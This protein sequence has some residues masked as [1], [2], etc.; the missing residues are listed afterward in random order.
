MNRRSNTEAVVA[1][2]VLMMITGMASW[3]YGDAGYLILQ[4]ILIAPMF[5]LA[6][7]G[8]RSYF[9]EHLDEARGLVRQAQF[10]FLNAALL[11][12]F[13]TNVIMKTDSN[14][15]RDL[16]L[17]GIFVI[18]YAGYRISMFWYSRNTRQRTD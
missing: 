8:L 11:G 14:I 17:F 4:K 13:I 9:P 18:I 7:D 1:T 2:L 16:L 6:G 15:W 12:A 5:L 3:L 10:E